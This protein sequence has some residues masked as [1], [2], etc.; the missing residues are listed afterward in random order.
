[1]KKLILIPMILMIMG[2]ALAAL[3]L[4][5]YP[6][7]LEGGDILIDAAIGYASA[8]GY[9]GSGTNLKIPPVSAGVEY[10]LPVQ[11]P[12]S[13]GGVVAFWR[14]GWEYYNYGY[15]WTYIVGGA[16]A[17]WHWNFDIYLTSQGV[18]I[19]SLRVIESSIEGIIV[20][21]MEGQEGAGKPVSGA[22]TAGRDFS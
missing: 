15:T 14:Y 3:D 17:N 12:I 18:A 5:T 4:F 20:R 11:V 13:V 10:A 1:M 6:P 21:I 19:K 22:G 16:R 7:P 9:S 8:L 2:G